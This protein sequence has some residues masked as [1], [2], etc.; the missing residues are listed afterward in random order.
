MWLLKACCNASDKALP[1]QALLLGI[2]RAVRRVRAR[3]SPV[4]AVNRGTSL[5]VVAA[6]ETTRRTTVAV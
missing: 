3:T 5:S 6:G 2:R 4:D 1:T